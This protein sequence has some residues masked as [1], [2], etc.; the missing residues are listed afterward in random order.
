MARD[1]LAGE[2]GRAQPQ[3]E[4]LVSPAAPVT[5]TNNQMPENDIV[6]APPATQKCATNETLAQ[7]ALGCMISQE[8]TA[9]CCRA[10]FG[11]AAL[12]PRKPSPCG[13]AKA[14]AAKCDTSDSPPRDRARS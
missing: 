13:A 9:L 14:R 3:E 8:S 12:G 2:G 1:R 5:Y 4:P 10:Y 11:F 7:R 6:S